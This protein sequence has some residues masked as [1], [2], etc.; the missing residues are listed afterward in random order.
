MDDVTAVTVAVVDPTVT[1]EPAETPEVEA[2]VSVV[3][4]LEA[5]ATVVKTSPTVMYVGL[6]E[7]A[8]VGATVGTVEGCGVGRP[9]T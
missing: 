5:V 1:V 7:G 8:T 4:V 6:R 3:E 2:T 9:L